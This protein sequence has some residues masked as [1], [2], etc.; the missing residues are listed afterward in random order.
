M[1][2]PFVPTNPILRFFQLYFNIEENNITFDMDVLSQL[3]NYAINNK[4][5]KFTKRVEEMMLR[6]AMAHGTYFREV[7]QDGKEVSLL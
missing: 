4:E 3:Y 1:I 6:G 5:D 2:A 7:F